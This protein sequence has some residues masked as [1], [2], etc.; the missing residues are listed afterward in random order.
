MDEVPQLIP[1][2]LPHPQPTH[3]RRPAHQHRQ[4]P[5]WFPLQPASQGSQAHLAG[6]WVGGRGVLLRPLILAQHCVSST[7]E[8][9][10]AIFSELAAHSQS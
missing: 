2:F 9:R 4:L 10:A 8:I 3:S 7:A 5:L 1:Q 6:S